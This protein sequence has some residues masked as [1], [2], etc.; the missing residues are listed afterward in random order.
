MAAGAGVTYTL[1]MRIPMPF[2]V[3]GFGGIAGLALVF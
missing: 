2:A 1:R 3:F